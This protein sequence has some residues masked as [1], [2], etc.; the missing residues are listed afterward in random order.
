MGMNARIKSLE[1]FQRE[2]VAVF[3][4]DLYRNMGG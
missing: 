2:K 3:M 1:I 4:K